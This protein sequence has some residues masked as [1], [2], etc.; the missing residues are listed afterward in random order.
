MYSD[1]IP[2]ALKAY[3]RLKF[4]YRHMKPEEQIKQRSAQEC[5]L[6]G[7]SEGLTLLELKPDV[8]TTPENALMVCA[9]CRSQIEK[10][11]P[12]NAAHWTCLGTSMW[13]EVPAVQVIAWRMLNRL[14]NEA[15]ASDHLDVLYLDDE[16]LSWAKESGDHHE[17]QEEGIHV[18]SNGAPLADGDSVVITKTLDV[19]GSS[20]S[21]KLGTVVKNIRLV[22]GNP[23]QIEGR[24]E[25]QLIVILTKYLR[26]QS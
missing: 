9:E 8:L 16:T 23:E 17:L 24:V 25:G 2:M 7:A 3:L 6:C 26:K 13:S 12:M 11:K 10:T 15:W 1:P 18:D 14:K 20:L 22:P 21:A 5:E 4:P 19:K